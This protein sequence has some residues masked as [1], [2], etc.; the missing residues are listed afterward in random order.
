MAISRTVTDYLQAHRV[1]YAVFPHPR[2][3]S[4]RETAESVVISA[5]QL[6]KAVVLSDAHGY[7]MAVVPSDRHVSMPRLSQL[8]GRR[9]ELAAEGRIAPVFKDCEVGAIPPMGPAYGMETI[10]DD[11]LVG[12]P[13][14]YF[15]AGDHEEVI[16]VDGETFLSLLKSA[17]H[18]QFTH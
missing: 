11:S 17:R 8:L 6:A 7:L 9:L 5:Q 13:V 3:H 10:L 1:R 16:Q 12:E 15:E 2:T 18:G 4:S 14:V